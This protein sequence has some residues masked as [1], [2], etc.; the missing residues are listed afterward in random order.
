MLCINLSEYW[1]SMKELSKNVGHSL[2]PQVV[3]FTPSGSC[4]INGK[5]ERQNGHVIQAIPYAFPARS[6]NINQTTSRREG[7][8]TRF[9]HNFSSIFNVSPL[10][11]AVFNVRRPVFRVRRQREHSFQAIGPLC[12]TYRAFLL[13]PSVVLFIILSKIKITG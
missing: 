5:R 4:T 13:K 8:G 7:L 6:N 9:E 1:T 10:P 12:Y 2:S 3:P 11:F